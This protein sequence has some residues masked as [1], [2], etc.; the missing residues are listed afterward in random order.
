MIAN[1]NSIDVEEE[2]QSSPVR[3]R[4]GGLDNALGGETATVNFSQYLNAQR[5]LSSQRF[6]LQRRA[7]VRSVRVPT[8]I[9]EDN[10]GANNDDDDN[11]RSK[12]ITNNH[13]SSSNRR[14]AR[15]STSDWDD[16]F[17][18]L[19]EIDENGQF[20]D[21]H[22]HMKPLYAP[23]IQRQRWGEDQVLPHVNW[24]EFSYSL[25][26]VLHACIFIVKYLPTH[27]LNNYN[28]AQVIYSSTSSTS[29]WHIISVLW[30]N[31]P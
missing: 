1:N 24:G 15:L 26:C 9:S 30:S 25:C 18:E 22:A 8:T 21:A 28:D 13:P 6:L 5:Q 4:G 7:S 29:E 31:H 11:G 23:P 14:L 27:L 3:R 16:I 17:E 10:E 20:H 19:G 12:A 2:Q